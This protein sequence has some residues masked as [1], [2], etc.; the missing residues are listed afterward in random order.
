M[1][2]QAI[3]VVNRASGLSAKRCISS[4]ATLKAQQVTS[5][6]RTAASRSTALNVRAEISYVMIKPDGVQRGLVGSIISRFEAKGFQLKGLKM[7]R[8]PRELAEE[9]YSSLNT[10]P[11]FKDLVNYIISGPVVCIVRLTAERK[12]LCTHACALGPRI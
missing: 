8:C 5:S 12:L 7:F 11:F 2:V 4:T 3:V 1:H 6:V 10:K 9:H